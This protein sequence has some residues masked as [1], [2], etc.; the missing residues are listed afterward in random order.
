[1]LPAFTVIP[2]TDK[3]KHARRSFLAFSR[4][5]DFLPW[6]VYGPPPENGSAFRVVLVVMQEIEGDVDVLGIGRVFFIVLVIIFIV[7]IWVF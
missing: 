5:D 6:I 3:A 7:I 2:V 1:V 4:Q